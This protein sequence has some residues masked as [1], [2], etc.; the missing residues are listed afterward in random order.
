MKT[1]FQLMVAP[2]GAR[3]TKADHKALPITPLEVAQTAR[4]CEK[5]GATAIHVHA[6]DA[7]GA[8]SLDP[9]IYADTI[10][11]IKACSKIAIQISTE[12]AG[13]FDVDVQRNCLAKVPATDASVSL[14]EIARDPQQFCEIYAMAAARG[15]DVQHILYNAD[16]VTELLSCF[17]RHE[18]APQSRRAI[19]VLGRYSVDQRSTPADLKPFVRALGKDHLNWSACAFGMEEHNCLLAALDQGGHVRIGFENNRL[20]PD[21]QVFKDNAASVSAF[22]EAAS[23]AGFQPQGITK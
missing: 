12:S 4:A 3:L 9:E 18:I 14:R 23:Q 20:A 16:E 2:N 11:K 6:R 15:I 5:A 1:P 21:G 13:I 17:E 19:F 22:V 8:H 7:F 10:E